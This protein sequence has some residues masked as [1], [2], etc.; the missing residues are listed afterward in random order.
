MM[1][2]VDWIGILTAGVAMWPMACE[3]SKENEDAAGDSD[4]DADG[5]TDGDSDGDTD[6]PIYLCVIICQQDQQVQCPEGTTCTETTQAKVFI[7]YP[8]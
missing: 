5:D 2:T 4:S 6:N 3:N 7:C 8:E 1:R